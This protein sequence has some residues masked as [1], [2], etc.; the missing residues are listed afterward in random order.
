[1][2]RSF[3][4]RFIDILCMI[5]YD[6]QSFLLITL[7][8]Q[9]N[10]LCAAELIND[11]IKRN[12]PA[13]QESGNTE[14]DHIACQNIVPGIDS[15]LLRQENADKIRA[16]GRS[17]DIQAETDGEAVDQAAEYTDEQD[18]VC[19]DVNRQNINEDTGKY[20]RHNGINREFFADVPETQI[21]RE[22]V[23]DYIKYGRTGSR[24]PAVTGIHRKILRV[25]DRPF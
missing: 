13:K 15:F 18:V 8:Q 24:S 4:D 25:A 23:Q 17:S 5:G 21:Y 7:I 10:D 19:K 2:V 14:D 12:L 11:R 9:L 1:M 6:K 16:A 20:D 22:Q 3:F